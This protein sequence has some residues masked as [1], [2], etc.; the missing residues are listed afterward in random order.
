MDCP[1][2]H[3]ADLSVIDSREADS[4]SI[5]RRRVCDGCQFRFTTYERI[6]PQKLLVE[7][8]NGSLEPFRREKIMEGLRRAVEKRNV[9]LE[10]LEAICDK[11]ELKF[12]SDGCDRVTTKQIG[13]AVVRELKALDHVAYLR[14]ASVYRGFDNL[15]AFEKELAKIKRAD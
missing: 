15:E 1:R 6:E 3:K 13:E 10:Q 8:R 11:L 2:C 9:N 5:R 12:F 4:D 14:F 7:K